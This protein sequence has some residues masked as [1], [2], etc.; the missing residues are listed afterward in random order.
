MRVGVRHA[1]SCLWRA[2]ELF[3]DL[4][5]VERLEAGSHADE[6]KLGVAE[7]DA[8]EVLVPLRRHGL[9][10]EQEAL[11]EGLVRLGARVRV[12]GER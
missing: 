2:L 9:E 8:H 4:G 5:C 3:D 10:L 7:S 12:K 1:R 6:P 11:G